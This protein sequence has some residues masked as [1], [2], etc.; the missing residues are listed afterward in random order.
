MTKTAIHR[1][2]ATFRTFTIWSDGS[3][4]SWHNTDR[5]QPEVIN[6]DIIKTAENLI[7]LFLGSDS[8]E[9]AWLGSV[10]DVIDETPVETLPG[11]F[12]IKRLTLKMA[13]GVE[14]T[15][16]VLYKGYSEGYIYEAH[17]TLKEARGSFQQWKDDLRYGGIYAR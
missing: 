6:P 12:E 9:P 14:K 2:T 15:V 1:R 8:V 5:S 4:S 17:D 3:V 7:L 13:D 10:R 11:G 16:Y